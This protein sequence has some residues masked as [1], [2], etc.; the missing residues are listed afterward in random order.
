MGKKN[1][2]AG[3]N[4]R[5]GLSARVDRE[6]EPTPIPSPG[7]ILEY[8]DVGVVQLDRNHC[9][10]YVNTRA[11]ELLER[12]REELVGQGLPDVIPGETL[13]VLRDELDHSLTGNVPVSFE[14][15]YA[16][17]TPR[18]LNFRSTPSGWGLTLVVQ[19]VTSRRQAEEVLKESEDRYHSLF[20]NNHAVM[21]LIRPGT[22]R[23]MDANPAAEA[24]YGY[25]REQ[26]SSMSITDI[27]TLESDQV[28]QEMEKA[29]SQEQRV[30]LFRHRLSSG[31]LRDV[32]AYSGPI[33]VS[34]E[35]LLYSIVHDI[36]GLKEAQEKVRRLNEELELKV[37]ERTGELTRAV[38]RLQSQ[39]EVLQAIIDNIPV[40][41]AFYDEAGKVA[42]INRA[43]EEVSGWSGEEMQGRDIVSAIFPDPDYRRQVLRL[44]E[45]GSLSWNDFEMTTRSG[46]TLHA[47]WSMVRT[48]DGSRIGI[49]IDLS[50]RRKMELDTR[51]LVTAVEQSGEGI[52]IFSP[53]WVVEYANPAYEAMSGYTRE[54][55]IG[56]K[57]TS[58]T[59]YLRESGFEEVI[60]HVTT[61]REEWKGRQKRVRK[62]TGE[63]FSISV[64]VTPVFSREGAITNFIEIVRDITGELRLQDQLFQSQKLEA[65]GRLAGGIAHDLK[66]VL[67]PI[68][69]D[70]ELA[71]MDVPEGHPAHGPLREIM[72][73]ARMGTDLV[74]QIVTF[75]RQ[76][77]PEKRPV[78]IEQVL[79]EALDFLMSVLPST[80]EVRHRL[81]GQGSMVMADPTRV[82]QVLI[83]LGINAGHAMREK[84]GVL[85]V[86]LRR[87]SLS[88]GEAF[89]F[90]PDIGAGRYVRIVVRDNGEGMD[91]RIMERIFEPFFTTR[92]HDEGSGM[93]LPVV[94]GIVKEHGGAVTVWSRPGRGSVFS[95]LLP[96]MEESEK[97]G[98]G[99]PS[100]RFRDRDP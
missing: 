37:R 67:S 85:E 80:I 60:E 96:A 53:D 70:A 4:S 30:F 8:V 14:I 19:D 87:E 51:Q 17:G 9:L 64:T 90:S 21:L 63:D 95:V 83:N 15:F 82:K 68:V 69:M 3:E 54:E 25:T 2:N 45:E 97:A 92:K 35:T 18:W 28:Q 11:A 24:F 57:I 73:A 79:R 75:S 100:G 44:M 26:L 47:S 49:G 39:R 58:L 16:G 93:G 74:R 32:A 20:E 31:E 55:L 98:G 27:N 50:E 43:L 41:L 56:R 81:A 52:V 29:W 10:T 66:S 76:E 59:D 77:P 36:T 40:M 65:V 86:E 33:R 84:G 13:P 89:S 23:I 7:E 12:S 38:D 78:V 88:A 6:R 99:N 5:D 61:R 48:P 62:T 42:L 1:G 72:Q 94:H 91:R 34:G 22:G 46:G 71:L